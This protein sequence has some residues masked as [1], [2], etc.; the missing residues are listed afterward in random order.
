MTTPRPYIEPLLKSLAATGPL[1]AVDAAAPTWQRLL[2]TGGSQVRHLAASQVL[3]TVRHLDP[4]VGGVLALEE[5]LTALAAE[6]AATLRVAGYGARAAVVAGDKW[7]VRQ[8]LQDAG[9]PLARARLARQMAEAMAGAARIGYPV[10][11]RPRQGTGPAQRVDSQAD[12][13]L[14]FPTA[15]A[16]D[17]NGEVLVEAFQE[18]SIVTAVCMTQDGYSSVVAVIRAQVCFAPAAAVTQQLVDSGDPLRDQAWLTHLARAALAGFGVENG[19]SRITLCLTRTG[20]VI[21]NVTA[22]LG[23]DLTAPLVNLATGVDLAAE[24]AAVARGQVRRPPDREY[25]CAAAGYVY[26]SDPGRIDQLT[27]GGQIDDMP[28]VERLAWEVAEGDTVAITPGAP[29]SRLAHVI[30]TGRENNQCTALLQ[31]VRA[32][33]RVKMT[34]QELAA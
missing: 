30:V 27:I 18:G 9:C 21:L 10:V 3:R 16:S 14:V 25:K 5:P 8:R 15:A 11:V 12:L 31:R 29:P 28:W 19:I 23:T 17:P 2:L 6:V 22:H 33:L 20:P 7:L 24:A 4:P 26:A 32:Q 13:A 34:E 1:L